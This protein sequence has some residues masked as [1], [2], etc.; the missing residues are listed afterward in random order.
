MNEDEVRI[1]KVDSAVYLYYK[2]IG[3]RFVCVVAKHLNDEGHIIST[4]P[5]DAIKEGAVKWKK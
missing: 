3:K 1:S 4:H 5:T 2:R